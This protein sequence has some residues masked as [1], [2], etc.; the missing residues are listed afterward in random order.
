MVP[1]LQ[2]LQSL[3]MKTIIIKITRSG[4]KN[5]PFDIKDQYGNIISSGERLE[6]LVIGKGFTV[7]DDVSIVTLVD[8]GKCEVEISQP[9]DVVYPRQ[10]TDDNYTLTNT[11]C[12]WRHLTDITKFNHFYGEIHPY[13]IE[14]PFVV[15][16]GRNEILQSVKDYTVAYIYTETDEYVFDRTNKI[17]TDDDYFNKAVVYNGQQ[18]SGML[19]LVPKPKH[20]LRSYLLYPIYN[21]DSKTITFTK[22]DS[23]YNFNTFWDIVKDKTKPLFVKS[24]DSLSIDKVVNQDNMEYQNIRSFM[25]YPLRGK[26]TKVRMILDDKSNVHLVTN[27]NLTTSQISYK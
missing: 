1:Q 7:N 26:Y 23:F 15:T 6:D 22:S 11:S 12:L 2:L 13:M 9:V 27:F 18:S 14:F 20:N 4:N 24:C 17:E 16:T 19:E 5:G 21:S 25:K 8:T 10:L 3:D